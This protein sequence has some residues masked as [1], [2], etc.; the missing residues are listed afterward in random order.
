MAKL[1]FEKSSFRTESKAPAHSCL[2]HQRTLFLVFAAE[3]WFSKLK[4][5][6]ELKLRA[7]EM[8]VYLSW[9]WATIRVEVSYSPH[10]SSA[11]HAL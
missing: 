1:V 5:V 9:K 3:S 10:P 7:W 6:K 11:V 4:G 2:L 8:E